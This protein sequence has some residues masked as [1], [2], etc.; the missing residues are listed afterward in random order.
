M[1]L[2]LANQK[3][4]LKSKDGLC[5]HGGEEILQRLLGR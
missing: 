2:Q 4:A 1:H 3:P 5:P